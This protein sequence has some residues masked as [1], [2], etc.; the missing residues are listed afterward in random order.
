MLFTS[1]YAHMKKVPEN[2]RAK[3]GVSITV[4]APTFWKGRHYSLLAPTWEMVN[5]HRDK[6]LG[7]DHY[8]TMYLRLLEQRG[9]TPQQVLEALGPGSIMLCFCGRGKFCHRHV[10][11]EWLEQG[12]VECTEFTNIDEY[13]SELNRLST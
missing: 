1:Y 3:M 13:R 5:A 11:A 12:G 9:I 7:D 4:Q 2:I 8:I 10:A 6:Q